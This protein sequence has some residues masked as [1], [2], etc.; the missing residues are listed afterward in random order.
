MLSVCLYPINV[1]TAEPIGSKYLVATNFTPKKFNEPS[2]SKNLA[3]TKM[4]TFI[5]FENVPIQKEKP[6]QIKLATFR[7]TIKI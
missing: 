3:W 5:N 4:L 2:I 1:K 6:A 7:A